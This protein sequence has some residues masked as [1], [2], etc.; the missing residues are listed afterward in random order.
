[1]RELGTAPLRGV[2]GV[3]RERER[4]TLL[5][6]FHNGPGKGVGGRRDS[7]DQHGGTNAEDGTGRGHEGF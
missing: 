3:A 2:H 4:E 7:R 6:I 5:G 1:M